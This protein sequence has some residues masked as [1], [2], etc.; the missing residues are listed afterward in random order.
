MAPSKT[1]RPAAAATASGPREID[2]AGSL[3]SL[4]DKRTK[5]GNQAVTTIAVIEKA[6]SAQLRVGISSRHG[7]HKLELREATPI[8][9]AP[10]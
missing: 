10:E 9:R 2:P 3:I 8:P 6:P 4:G 1:A 7:T 5:A